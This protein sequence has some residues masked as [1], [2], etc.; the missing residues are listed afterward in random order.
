MGWPTETCERQG[1]DNA[2]K[3]TIIDVV[4]L[5]ELRKNEQ[6]IVQIGRN[7]PQN[8]DALP[9]KE[10]SLIYYIGGTLEQLKN[11]LH[12]LVEFFYHRCTHPVASVDK[13]PW[14]VPGDIAVQ[15]HAQPAINLGSLKE[16]ISRMQVTVD[17]ST[18]DIKL[19]ET[20]PPG[21]SRA[22]MVEIEVLDQDQA[23]V[24]WDGRTYGYRARFEEAQI[25]R[26]QDN[27]RV[28]PEHMRD[29]TQA[30]N[31]ETVLGIFGNA[32]LRDLVCNV[33]VTG[34]PVTADGAVKDLIADLKAKPNL[35]FEAF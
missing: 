13:K 7:G 29:F 9:I 6:I 35:F 30:E 28:L 15:M 12:L 32:V 26:V 19:W 17:G 33:R 3:N 20:N 34:E 25:P 24:A 18:E 4:D 2:K 1:L 31:R 16:D 22:M 27:L 21:S 10:F 14:P 11:G 23:I 5:Q 8:V